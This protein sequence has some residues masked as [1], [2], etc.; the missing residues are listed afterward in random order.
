MQSPSDWMYRVVAWA[1]FL[2]I[3]AVAIYG[4]AAS[5]VERGTALAIGEVL[6]NVEW[7]LPYFAKPVSYFS[8]ASVALFYSGMRLWESR[9]RKWPMTLIRFLQLFAFVVAFAAA[10][11]VLYNFMVWGALYNAGYL[12]G[13]INPDLANTPYP[14][15][16]N[17]DFSTKAFTALFAITAYCVYF[18][19]RIVGSD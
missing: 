7:P 5:L 11:E 14:V 13:I 2:T 17:L 3:V 10:Y 16:W 8:I 1:S 4:I 18:L 9:I 6:V 19:R 15:P 12:R